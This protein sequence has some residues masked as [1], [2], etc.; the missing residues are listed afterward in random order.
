MSAILDQFVTFVIVLAAALYVIWK[1]FLPVRTK[2]RLRYLASGSKAPCEPVSPQGG[3]AVGCAGC[4]LAAMGTVPAPG[5]RKAS[6]RR[7]AGR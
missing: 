1:I 5:T 2:T 7:K 6:G 3:C 4:S